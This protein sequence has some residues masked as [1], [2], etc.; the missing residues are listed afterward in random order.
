[1]AAVTKKQFV[2]SAFWKILEQFL[3]KGVSLLIA[4]LLARIIDAT[5]FGLIALTAVFTNLSD[6]LVDGGFSTALISKKEVDDVDYSNSLFVSFSTSTALYLITFF[7]APF[8]AKYYDQSL[9]TALLR[10][11]GV[12]FFIQAFAAT[13]T[14]VVTRQMK[15]RTLFICNLISTIISGI[16]GVASAYLIVKKFPENP[17]Y[18][19][20]A[21]VI[22]RLLQQTILTIILFIA[23]R[24]R[25]HFKINWRRMRGLLF[26]SLGIVMASLINFVGSSLYSL[27]IGKIYSVADLGY[28]DKGPSLPM[29][30]SLYLFGA[31]TSVLLPTLVSYKGDKVQI[32]YIVRRVVTLTAFLLAPMMVG[33]AVVSKEIIVVL[34]TDKWMPMLEIMQY[35]CLYYL[36]TPFMLINVQVFLSLGHTAMRIKTELIRLAMMMIGIFVFAVGLHCN[37]YQLCLISAIIAV[38]SALVSFFDVWKM[39]N[40][41]LLEALSDIGLPLI[42]AAT[43]GII[44]MRSDA[45]GLFQY[46]IDSVTVSDLITL[47]IKVAFGIVFYFVV[48]KAMKMPGYSEIFDVFNT[49]L[50]RG[51]KNKPVE[52]SSNA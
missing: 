5:A 30:I 6:I 16:I 34:Y 37:I 36:A 40:Y 22:Q 23:V 14:A 46:G 19:V 28:Y 7:I 13:R 51:N 32:K 11:I 50:H 2:S 45:L 9:L 31:I 44:I 12:T 42:V 8:V 27:I 24:W 52:E 1:M 48:A 25:L 49:Y 21:I 39:L 29:Q 47:L 3:S 33:M 4:I 18:G 17:E 41:N 10:V 15:F 26:A 38:L 35:S 43:M 20:W